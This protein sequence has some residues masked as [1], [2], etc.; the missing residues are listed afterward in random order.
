MASTDTAPTDDI[1]TVNSIASMTNLAM[2]RCKSIDD[3]IGE[4][5]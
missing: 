1:V 4:S 3:L 2:M 5:F